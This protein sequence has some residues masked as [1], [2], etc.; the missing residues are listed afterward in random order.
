[1]STDGNAPSASIQSLYLTSTQMV[2]S[3][4]RRRVSVNAS[5]ALGLGIIGILALT[6][7]LAPVF[8]T[9]SPLKQDVANALV[10]PGSPGH[11]LGTDQLGRDIWSQLLYA[12][13]T[14]LFVAFVALV[15]PF[16]IGLVVGT[17]A[18]YHG[19]VLDAIVV[20]LTN[21]TFAFP[22]FVLLIALVFILGQGIPT[23]VIAITLVDWVAYASLAR[24]V[25]RRERSMQ[26]VLA[27][28]VGGVPRWR[29][30]ARHI[31]PNIIAQPVVYAM[32]DA[33][34]IILFV[35]TL[36]FLG[37]GVP[38]P[39]PDWGTMISN[40]TPY[41]D[42]Q[43]WLAVIPGVPICVTGFGLSLI[44]DG[45]AEKFDTR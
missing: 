25:V 8:S 45:L 41:F 7:I 39:T 44:A 2:G 15:F 43:W 23:I 10:P 28:R 29:I 34:A 21:V 26:Y 27:A 3:V 40:G 17:L 24:T 33:V 38:P 36:G 11:L 31:R 30:L 35:T 16:A 4:V 20:G 14:D 5:L 42:T 22:V 19:G 37:L 1:V 6:A 12:G 13:R 18:G 9:V 32:S